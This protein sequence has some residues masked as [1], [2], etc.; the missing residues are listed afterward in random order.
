M[1]IDRLLRLQNVST[2]VVEIGSLERTRVEMR[3][4]GNP[5]VTKSL[6]PEVARH[7][8]REEIA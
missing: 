7:H 8:Q 5:L 2:T 3:N 6:R 1:E 4:S